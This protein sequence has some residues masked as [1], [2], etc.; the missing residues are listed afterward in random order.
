MRSCFD[1]F[2]ALGRKKAF[3]I[4]VVVS[5]KER[6]DGMFFAFQKNE[7]SSETLIIFCQPTGGGVCEI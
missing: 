2:T 1:T 4:I 5:R 3:V 7:V 6:E